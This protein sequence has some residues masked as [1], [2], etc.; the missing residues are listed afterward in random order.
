MNNTDKLCIVPECNKELK[1]SDSKYC[2]MHRARISRTGTTSKMS[3]EERFLDRCIPVTETGCW[4]WLGHL[5]PSGYGR[6]S[7]TS[8]KELAHRYSY[9]LFVGEISSGMQ[10]NHRCD[11][12]SCVNPDHLYQGTQKENVKDCIDRG[13]FK[14]HMNSPFVEGNKY[15]ECR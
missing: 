3:H 12:P 7:M 9:K 6:F 10:I 1:K 2:S 11:N 15:H 4:L 14:G 5:N 8:G 13:R